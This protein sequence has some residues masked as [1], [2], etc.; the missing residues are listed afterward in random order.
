MN[1]NEFEKM[2]RQHGKTAKF[3]VKSPFNIKRKEFEIMK[4]KKFILKKVLLTAV[5]VS[6]IGTTVFSA[7]SFLSAREVANKVG[8]ATLSK[9]FEK[10]EIISETKTD[11]KYKATVLGITS[12]E[13]ISDFKSSVWDV[14]PNRT[15]VSVAVEKSDG[16][17]MTYD[18]EILVTPL[19]QGLKPWQYNI[20]TMNGGYSAQIIDGVLYRII[21]CDNVEYFS[22]K[23]IYLAVTDSVFLNNTQYD[24]DEKTGKITENKEYDGTNIL[25]DLK[26]DKSKADPKKA[27]EYLD[28]LHEEQGIGE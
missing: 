8:D 17:E 11:G 20:V 26:L 25:F 5:I 3:T 12:G 2:L 21:E 19:I 14:F 16:S 27:Q 28:K 15:Y 10:D 9:Y 1:M 22:D 4:R 13:N 23:N 24:F 7:V 6:L 18:D